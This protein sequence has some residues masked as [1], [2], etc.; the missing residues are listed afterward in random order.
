[1]LVLLNFRGPFLKLRRPF[2]K[3]WAR[4]F[5]DDVFRCQTGFKR[6]FFL[7]NFFLHVANELAP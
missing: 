1:M 2:E 3:R 7:L 4:G 6:F 5:P